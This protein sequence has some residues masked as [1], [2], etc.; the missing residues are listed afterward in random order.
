[1]PR[2]RVTTAPRR[3]VAAALLAALAS[4]T[5][6]GETRRVVP[7]AESPPAS[8][9][10]TP[11]PSTTLVLPP[12]PVGGFDPPVE[13]RFDGA[14]PLT[15]EVARRPDQRARGLM[16]RPALGERSGMLFLFPERGAGGFYMLGTLIPLSI[17]YVDGDRV[18]STAEMTPCPGQDCP[19]Y[20]PAASYTIAVEAVAGFFPR[21]DVRAG[22]RMR[23]VGS[24]RAPE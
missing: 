14:P 5:Q 3:A 24:T 23:I 11:G 20:A 1:M 22:T 21:W 17:A 8:A 19:T 12:P 4:C 6:A 16:Q 7:P 18:V 2:P 9:A 15:V 13:V 10:G